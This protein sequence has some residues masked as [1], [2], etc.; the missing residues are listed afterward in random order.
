MRADSSVVGMP[1]TVA[2]GSAA[3]RCPFQPRLE[4]QLMMLD[5][6]VFWVQR[7]L[8]EVVPA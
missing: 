2:L 7:S 8:D 5:T 1:T 4:E 6:E 3:G